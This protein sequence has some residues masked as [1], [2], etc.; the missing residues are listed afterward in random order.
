[1]LDG[2]GSGHGLWSW[3]AAAAPGT[4]WPASLGSW[5]MRRFGRGW[6]GARRGCLVP[7]WGRLLR[8]RF[9]L[10]WRRVAAKGAL[11][12]EGG[13]WDFQDE[14][15]GKE[16]T[17]GQNLDPKKLGSWVWTHTQTKTQKPNVTKILVYKSTKEKKISWVWKIWW[18]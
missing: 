10:W 12:W 16:A 18:V 6:S 13:G 14:K 7:W 4:F 8:C 9:V 5:R 2:S 15:E 17:G 1:M 11:K 3:G